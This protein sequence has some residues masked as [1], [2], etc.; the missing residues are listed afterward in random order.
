MW[1][2]VEGLCCTVTQFQLSL[3]YFE[4]SFRS[5]SSFQWCLGMAR[6]EGPSGHQLKIWHPSQL[7]VGIRDSDEWGLIE[8]T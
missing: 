8:T 2:S 1:P 4:L 6:A 7:A 3:R 5:G